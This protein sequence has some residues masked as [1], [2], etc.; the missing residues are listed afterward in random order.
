MISSCRK[1]QTF[2]VSEFADNL[3]LQ[4]ENALDEV[5][6][7][8]VGKYAVE[9]IYFKCSLILNYYELTFNATYRCT[10]DNIKNMKSVSD[11]TELN[12]AISEGLESFSSKILI[13]NEELEDIGKNIDKCFLEAYFSDPL[14]AIALYE[15]EYKTYSNNKLPNITE[16]T[17]KYVQP[18]IVLNEKVSDMEAEIM[19][20]SELAQNSSDPFEEIKIFHD[21]LALNTQYDESADI[22]LKTNAGPVHSIPFSIYGAIIDKQAVSEAYALTMKELCDRNGITCVIVVGTMNDE[23]HVWNK[24]YIDNKWYNLDVSAD[25]VGDKVVGY[26]YF[27]TT[28]EVFLTEYNWDNLQNQAKTPLTASQLKYLGIDEELLSVSRYGE[29]DQ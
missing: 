4:I 14:H 15:Y 27:C 25:A 21:Y 20:I 2:H 5:L 12:L 24:V 11:M 17:V 3:D 28:D 19:N 1:K 22:S 16:I 26:K 23:Y 7:T 9:N 8:P 29:Q 10:A 13:Y 6:R 18:R